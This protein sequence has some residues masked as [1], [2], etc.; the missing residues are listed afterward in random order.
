MKPYHIK[1][2]IELSA[3][4]P[5]EAAREALDCIINGDAKV[6]TVTLLAHGKIGEET[7]VDLN[8]NPE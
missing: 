4:N 8:E 6:F 5:L 3:D 2:E 1:W 7:E